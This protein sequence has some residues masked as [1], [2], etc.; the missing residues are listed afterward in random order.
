MIFQV[1]ACVGIKQEVCRIHRFF[2]E[3]GEKIV[4]PIYSGKL[5]PVVNRVRIQGPLVGESVT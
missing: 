2:Y 5:Y 1:K 3:M 4:G